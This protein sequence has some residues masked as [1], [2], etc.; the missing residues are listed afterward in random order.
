M[1]DVQFGSA[2]RAVRIRIHK[3]QAAVAEVAGVARWDV[4]LLERGKLDRLRVRACV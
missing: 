1:D 4:S 3:T 2:I